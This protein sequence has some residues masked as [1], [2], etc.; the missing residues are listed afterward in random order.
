MDASSQLDSLSSAAAGD[1]INGV[2]IS[3][4]D[5]TSSSSSS[6]LRD[7]EDAPPLVKSTDMPDVLQQ[8]AIQATIKARQQAK[9]EGQQQAESRSSSS[10]QQQQ[11]R[12]K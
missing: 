2:H 6:S 10:K 1:H 9:E 7:S 11:R 8:H 12:A 3:Q 4:H 5:P